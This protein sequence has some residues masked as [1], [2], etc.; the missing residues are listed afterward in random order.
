MTKFTDLGLNEAILRAVAD[1]GFETPSEIQAK[2]IPILLES[3]T[4]MVSLAQT[5]TG[6]T[7]AFGFPLIQKIDANSKTTQGLILSPTRELCM[8]ITNELK[9]YSKFIPSL[10]IVAIYG[11]A[12]INDQARDIKRGAQIIV[13]TPG[14]M[15]DMISRRMID[16]SK[17]EYCV[18]DEA[19][20]ML[21][22]GFY[23]DITEILSHSPKEKSTW[24]FSATMPKEVSTIAKKFMKT[25][26]EI[27]VG[28]RNT[29]TKNVSHEYYLV[30]ARDRYQALRRL[31][32][33]H[34]D[35]FS[36]VFCRTKRDTQKV[37][38]NLIE[39]GYNAAALHGDL[40]QSQRDMVMK[41][42]RNRQ[43]QMLV[44]TDVAARGIDVD[45][46]T[47]VINY[48][49]PDEIEIYTHRSGR[50]GRAGKNGVSITIVSK[51]EVRKIRS[52]E[53]IIQQKFV[54]KEIP[55][56]MEICKIQ[57]FHLANNIKNTEI[58][59]DLE[60]YLPSINE[61]LGGLTKEDLINKV[62]SVEFSRFY[63]H[64]K[65]TKDLNVIE[66]GNDRG[67]RET[68]NEDTVRYFINIGS[69]D[70][71]D[72][73]SLKDFLRDL[74]NLGKDDVYR[75]DVKDSFSFFNTDSS[76]Q[77]L[78]L[79]IFEDFKLEGRHVNVEISKDGGGS[80]GGKNRGNRRRRDDGGGER[81]ERGGSDRG[82]RNDRGGSERPQ[83][84]ER[85]GSR[86]EK[87]DKKS[88]DFKPRENSKFSGGSNRR[89]TGGS[90]NKPT[91][92]GGR[93]RR[94]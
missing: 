32:D 3:D 91:G 94:M 60:A 83:R 80:G 13:A 6:K 59:K 51:S 72:W 56:G 21:N 67:E 43:I 53:K 27:T 37:A 35:I 90:D 48:Q 58:N 63:D 17:I 12:S 34:P 81:R 2:A 68:T 40:S 66:A 38:E 57:L 24:L 36:V 45:D 70:G 74:I 16:I 41:S 1:M 28:T 8:Q 77:E 61:V 11:G 92:T 29:G 33:A 89:S 62:F 20:E 75:V 44:A 55:N 23:E 73:M 4:D 64:Y 25:P 22:M 87:K 39:D 30:N 79:S 88:R 78:V 86:F 47:H 18:L 14:R 52:I 71:F 26:V 15:K 19:D 46:I 85:G 10:N 49:L 54:A 93:R 31:A 50:T 76:H 65:K 82:T 42:F 69:K 84:N 5:G 7:A 9:N